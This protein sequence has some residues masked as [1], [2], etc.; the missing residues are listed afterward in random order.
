MYT[1]SEPWKTVNLSIRSQEENETIEK[2]EKEALIFER[3]QR[4]KYRHINEGY[5]S[6]GSKN[7]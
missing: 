7:A 3:D 6:N 4:A 2:R 5:Y 1:I